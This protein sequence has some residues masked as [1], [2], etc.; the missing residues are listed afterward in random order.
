MR[1]LIL[2]AGRG[3]RM[4]DLTSKLPK[5]RTIFFGKEL[6]NWQIDS[7]KEAG[8]DELGIITGYLKE[9]FNHEA[10]YFTN[11]RWSETNMVMTLME[12]AE[13]L[14]NYDCIISYSDICYSSDAVKRLMHTNA[15]IAISYDPDWLNL[16]KI[17][18]EDPLSDAE[19]FKMDENKNLVE[20]G[21]KTDRLSDISG[22]FMGLIR[23]TPN[24]YRAIKNLIQSRSRKEQDRMDFTSLLNLMIQN[25]FKVATTPIADQWYEVDTE[26]D[27]KA[28]EKWRS[29]DDVFNKY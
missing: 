6:I 27:L 25:N 10:T 22:Q 11:K 9:T 17:R 1:A 2:A 16:W 12:A 7:L 5:C 15:D 3:S 8:L 23:I 14:E 24:G 26:S 18:M 21:K 13:W 28:Y 20:I 19:T 29:V 4:G